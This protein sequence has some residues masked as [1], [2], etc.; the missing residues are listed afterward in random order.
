MPLLGELVRFPILRCPHPHSPEAC[1]APGPTAQSLQ[2]EVQVKTIPARKESKVLA[3]HSCPSPPTPQSRWPCLC[4]V[5]SDPGRK[6]PG[7]G[8]G[9]DRWGR[10]HRILGGLQAGLA[11]LRRASFRG[12]QTEGSR[13]LGAGRGACWPQ[14]QAAHQLGQ[15]HQIWFQIDPIPLE[16]CPAAHQTLPGAM[17][18]DGG[19]SYV[20]S[21]SQILNDALA[22]STSTVGFF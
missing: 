16:D 21:T 13:T 14:C 1:S 17:G 6:G 9:G 2:L 15:S 11:R 10:G 12:S 3:C 4:F 7:P 19:A 20:P 22:V 5:P 18:W 8:Q